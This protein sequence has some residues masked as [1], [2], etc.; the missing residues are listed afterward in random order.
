MEER[1]NNFNLWKKKQCPLKSYCNWKII[2]RP[3]PSKMFDRH[4]VKSV[5]IR[6][7]SVPHFFAFGSEKLQTQTLFM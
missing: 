1:T 6:N 2:G 5:R 3:F 7:F 4:C